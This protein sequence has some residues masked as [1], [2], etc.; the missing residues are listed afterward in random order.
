M[1]KEEMSSDERK[2]NRMYLAAETMAET[3]QYLDAYDDLAT[4]DLNAYETHCSAILQLAIVCYCKSFIAS[5]ARNKADPKV[6]HSDVELFKERQ[7]LLD[8]HNLLFEKR[9]KLI[10]H[11]EWDFH[12]TKLVDVF[13]HPELDA[14]SVVRQS[15]K[16]NPCA[17][18]DVSAFHVLTE[19]LQEEFEAKHF[20]LDCLLR[21]KKKPTEIAQG[22]PRG[23]SGR[24]QI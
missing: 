6:D 17:G 22:G 20:E 1:S 5:K 23:M 8:L 19:L 7:D 16:H 18:I 3:R 21:E 9:H 13:S 4:K 10:A 14:F 15:R 2:A 24:R 12:A 11:T